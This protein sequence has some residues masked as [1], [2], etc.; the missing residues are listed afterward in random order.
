MQLTS[1]VSVYDQ[2][3]VQLHAPGVSILEKCLVLESGS[4]SRVR[5]AFFA[6]IVTAKIYFDNGL[7]TRD[8]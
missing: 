7:V 3:V 1:R 5:K 4:L 8:V 2:A 6:V